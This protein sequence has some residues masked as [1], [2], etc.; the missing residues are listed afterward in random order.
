MIK[1]LKK[2]VTPIIAVVMLLL[3]TL[4]LAG[5]A[6]VIFNQLGKQSEAQ[7][8]QQM[9]KMNIKGDIRK[10]IAMPNNNFFNISLVNLFSRRLPIDG[11]NTEIKIS[12]AGVDYSCKVDS[13]C[14]STNIVGGSCCCTTGDANKDNEV[15]GAG[16]IPNKEYNFVCYYK[17]N[18][19]VYTDYQVV[20]VYKE[21]GRE[22]DRE[23]II[24]G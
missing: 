15:T 1:M 21:D 5:M 16:L 9:M 6:M 24:V 18:F 17:E 20:W 13:S 4:S 12:V 14:D 8:K 10:A 7:I 11:K 23:A 19:N 22:L 3:I 2:S